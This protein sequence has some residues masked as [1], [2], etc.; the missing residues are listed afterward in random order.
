[1]AQ[2]CGHV[3]PEF[4]NCNSVGDLWIL[5]HLL[6]PRTNDVYRFAVPYDPRIIESLDFVG[7]E[8]G[9]FLVY[10]LFKMEV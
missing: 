2:D 3:C 8:F 4:Q 9:F 7:E 1:M 6:Y 10:S 5:G